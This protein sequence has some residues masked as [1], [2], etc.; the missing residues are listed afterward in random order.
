MDLRTRGEKIFSIFNYIFMSFIAFITLYPMWHILMASFSDPAEVLMHRGAYFWIRGTPQIRGYILVFENPSIMTGYFNT[1]IYVG[2]GTALSLF[3]TIL[4][5]YVLSRKGLYWNSIVMKAIVFT[6]FFHGG[7]VPFFIQVRNM[8]MM[9]T[10]WAI[11]LPTLVGTMNLI[12]LRTAFASAPE[13]L[14]ESAKLDGCSDWKIVWTI[15]LP[16]SKAAVAVIALFYAVGNWNAWF[17]ASIFLTD[18]SLWPIQLVLREILIMGDTSG[19]AD[20]GAVGQA[21]VER[22]RHLVRYTTII[23]ATVPV[24]FVYPFIQKYFVSGV[25]IGSLKE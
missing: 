1:L 25:M 6:M 13:S 24:L 4:G 9:D 16:I 15:I 7:L 8:G 19:M 11:I 23:V 10:R 14:I 21:G 3:I 18:R 20:I 17:N 2:V 5:A 22:Y 12:I